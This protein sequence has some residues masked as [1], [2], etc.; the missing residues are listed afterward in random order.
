MNREEGS[1][2]WS[3]GEVK[4]ERETRLLCD[5]GGQMK[6]QPFVR[7]EFVGHKL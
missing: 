7:S 4:R 3:W 2:G 5:G 1:S 6:M